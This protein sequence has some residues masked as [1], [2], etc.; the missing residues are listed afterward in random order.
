MQV[1]EIIVFGGYE[2]G[3]LAV[4]NDR[5]LIQT[6]DIVLQHVYHDKAGAVTWA[7]CA[8]RDYLNHT[9]YEAFDEAEQA[10][11]LPVINK[12]PDN[13]WYGTDGGADT[14]DKIFLLSIE[15]VACQ[16]F[17][18]SSRLLYQ[19]G[20]NQRYWFQRKD[21][22]NLNRQARYDGHSWWWWLRSSGRDNKRAVYIWGDGNIGIQGNGTFRYSSNTIHPVTKDNSG[23]VRPALW[24]NIAEEA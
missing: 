11:I 22:N 23:G 17:G 6:K 9:F 1:G 4:R 10:R 21:V 2:W 20:K 3:V 14:L 13:Q 5:M 18:D 16:Y 19:P 15:E 12:N 8:L 24:L 7:E